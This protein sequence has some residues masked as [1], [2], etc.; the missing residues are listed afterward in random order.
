MPW[1][2]MVC[3]ELNKVAPA[4][5]PAR[6]AMVVHGGHMSGLQHPPAHLRVQ[7]DG[8]SGQWGRKRQGWS[9]GPSTTR[10]GPE[11]ALGAVKGPVYHLRRGLGWWS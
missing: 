5:A 11:A 8:G 3:G 6:A 4:R 2:L 10:A 9:K 7:V 1:F